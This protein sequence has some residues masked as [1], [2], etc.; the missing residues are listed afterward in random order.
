MSKT[1]I[2]CDNRQEIIIDGGFDVSLIKNAKNNEEYLG[3]FCMQEK[4]NDSIPYRKLYLGKFNKE[5]ELLNAT[6]L[7]DESKRPLH[8]THAKGMGD[9][10]IRSPTSFSAIAYDNSQ[11]FMP[12]FLIGNIEN[13][14]IDSVITF[15]DLYNPRDKTGMKWL[16]LKETT[17]E[18]HIIVSYNPLKVMSYNKGSKENYLM[19]FQ[20]VFHIENCEV[21][22]CACVYIEQT[23]EHLLC[24]RVTQN[25]NYMYSMWALLNQQYKFICTSPPFLFETEHLKEKCTGMLMN[26]DSVLTMITREE[27]NYVYA[28]DLR[29]LYDFINYENYDD[30]L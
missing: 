4:I 9:G 16:I 17:E 20:K 6:E 2:I 24:L 10:T 21:N 8:V 28:F 14:V 13:G 15:P 11:V 19:H 27:K 30:N 7:V 3:I 12:S 1:I 29:T 26:G 18:F 25:G 22:G 5:F 23:K